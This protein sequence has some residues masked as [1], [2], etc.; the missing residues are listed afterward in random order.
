MLIGG[1]E[2]IAHFLA[3][4]FA[5]ADFFFAIA[6]EGWKSLRCEDSWPGTGFDRMRAGDGGVTARRRPR[7][8]PAALPG[9]NK[10]RPPFAASQARGAQRAAVPARAGAH[11]AAAAYAGL[12]GGGEAMV[13][14]SSPPASRPRP[15]SSPSRRRVGKGCGAKIAGRERDL[16]GCARATAALPRAAARGAL[17]RAPLRTV[18]GE[19][20]RKPSARRGSFGVERR[21]Q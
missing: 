5:A 2:V 4:G 13:L 12:I 11:A 15:S 8:S 7:G 17:Q 6:T 1:A 14:T 18:P 3:A 9:H 19:P 20:S 10:H 21:S 16:T